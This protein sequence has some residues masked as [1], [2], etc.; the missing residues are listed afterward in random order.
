MRDLPPGATGVVG[1]PS[2][3][4]GQ[5]GTDPTFD[6]D[7]ADE[8]DDVV[9]TSGRDTG[10]R[11][12]ATQEVDLTPPQSSGQI[13]WTGLSAPEPPQAPDPTPPVAETPSAA[14]AATSE[15]S[16]GEKKVVWS[17]S[18]PDRYSSF[19]SSGGRR[20]DY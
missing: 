12:G 16:T 13:S 3:A 6:H 14:P 8:G 5:G 10:P 4:M 7:D 15:E 20:D 2:V 1:D 17:S 11:D 19:G 9:D 18:P